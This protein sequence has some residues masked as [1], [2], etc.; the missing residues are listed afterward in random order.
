MLAL[1]APLSALLGGVG[2]LLLG[3]GLFGTLL[4]VRGE[5]E[6]FSA[7]TIGLISSG[8]FL[9]F[10]LGTLFAPTLIRRIGHI[11]AF[12]FCAAGTAALTLAHAVFVDPLAWLV[13]RI[14]V[15]ALLVVLYTVIESWLNASSPPERRAQV[16]SAYMLVNLGALALGQQFL[17]IADAGGFVLFAV[18]SMLISLAV[19][20]VTWT[21]LT[22]PPVLAV[23]RIGVRTLYR[24]APSAVIGTLASGLALGAFWGLGPLFAADLGLD[25]AGVASFM[26][27]TIVGGAA[28]QF[29]LGRL[30]DSRDRRVVLAAIG[31]LAAAAAVLAM[32]SGHFGAAALYVSMFMFGGL[33]FAVYP[34]SVA[35]LIDRISTDQVLAGSSTLLL[36][37]GVASAVGPSLAGLAMTRSGEPGALLAY[38]GMVFGAMALFVG[39]RRRVREGITEHDASFL[40]MLRTTPT[41]LELMPAA[42]DGA[43]EPDAADTPQVPEASDAPDAAAAPGR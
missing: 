28:L 23:P 4:A 26:G 3:S 8:Y 43:T 13:L 24:A 38:A 32:L 40:P 17:R 16:F 15:G 31:A 11:R 33:A 30:S 20:P 25:H 29:P 6:G 42:Q 19:M 34:L 36:V 1:I 7:Q 39:W 18:V 12:A 37:H 27:W 22:P 14:G 21:R 5:L 10:F 35:H 2:L 9:G 41:A